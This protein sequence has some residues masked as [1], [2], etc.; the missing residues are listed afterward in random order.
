MF[1]Q[2]AQWIRLMALF[3]IVLENKVGKVHSSDCGSF[4]ESF[5]IQMI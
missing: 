1:H 4:R 2:E 5:A 3:M